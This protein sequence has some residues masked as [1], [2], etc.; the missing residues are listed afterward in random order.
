MKQLVK[1]LIKTIIITLICT[2]IAF[3]LMVSVSAIMFRNRYKEITDLQGNSLKETLELL[4]TEDEVASDEFY[5]RI[6]ANSKLMATLLKDYLIDGKYTGEELFVDGKVVR[7]V[8]GVL[9]QPE[10]EYKPH[11]E[12]QQFEEA[13]ASYIRTTYYDGYS[14]ME[15]I[16]KASEIGDGYYY[17]DWTNEY[18]YKNYTLSDANRYSVFSGMEKA[19]EGVLLVA[20]SG[21]TIIYNESK[22]FDCDTIDEIG[23]DLENLKY[24]Y[25][26]SVNGESYVGTYVKSGVFNSQAV[27]LVPITSITG[28]VNAWSTVFL[29][30]CFIIVFT[31]IVWNYAVQKLV[32]NNILSEE[33]E[34]KY[35]PRRVRIINFSGA[36]IGVLVVLLSVS[37]IQSLSNL[38]SATQQGRSALNVLEKEIQDRI[39]IREFRSDD[40]RDW[41]IYYGKRIAGEISKNERLL[42]REKFEKINECLSTRYLMIYDENGDEICS[43]NQFINFSL[44]TK[45]SDP[46]ADFRRLLRGVDSI[47]HEP[48]YDED[49]GLE[50]QLIG[51]RIPF[52][53]R[54]GYGALIMALNPYQASYD[55]SRIAYGDRMRTL[56]LPGDIMMVVDKESGEI[57]DTNEYKIYASEISGLGINLNDTADSMMDYFTING[58]K[59]YGLAKD[60]GDKIYLNFLSSDSMSKSSIKLSVFAAVMFLAIYAVAMLMMS[61]GYTEQAYMEN[62]IVGTPTVRGSKIEIETTDGRKKQTV[63]PRKRFSFIPRLWKEMLPEQ[64]AKLAFE[65]MVSYV[66]LQIVD[67]VYIKRSAYDT[68]LGFIMQG[69]W[70][71][72]LNLF[73]IT[74]IIILVAGVTL[75]MM[76]IKFILYLLMSTMDTKGETVCR[77]AYNLLQYVA[78]I[79]VLYYAFGYLGFDTSA[80]LASVGFVT[81][82]VSLGSKDLVADVLAGLTIVFEGE[83][84]VGDMVEIGGYRGQ[85]QE[86]GVRST[87]LI[88]RGD[89]IKIIGN[90]DVKN[91]VNMTRLNSWLPIEVTIS[92]NEPLERVEEILDKNLPEIGKKIKEII[93]GPYYYGVLSMGK[94]IVTLSIMTECKEEDYY[95]VQRQLNKELINLFKQNEITMV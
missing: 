10:A 2:A 42:T 58:N 69:D 6:E 33:Q 91:V 49:T 28:P 84:Q 70:S 64:K 56:A 52:E 41:F 12:P 31:M 72:G 8:D 11:I 66:L 19:F 9:E 47:V 16:L 21:G 4:E 15:I 57:I 73:A 51:I 94:G 37:F 93:K 24:Q 55:K 32:F 27:L 67:Y 76:A 29:A 74:S 85:V 44:G 40:S 17:V 26:V 81:L 54:D 95:R 80:L 65:I 48:A 92:S 90:R 59:Y 60:A 30:V 35:H 25:T 68:L 3:I 7:Y 88:G 45:E 75:G 62:V 36:V 39:M 79:T 71:R 86:I 18:E 53:N 20:D 34:K 43:S 61:H 50:T 78:F 13:L 89:N 22:I 38:Y 82:A 14:D 46:T 5:R 23:I 1:K 77:L 83:Y 87:K 63:D